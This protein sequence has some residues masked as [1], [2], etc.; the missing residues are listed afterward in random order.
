MRFSAGIGDK[1]TRTGNSHAGGAGA[2]A[3]TDR[4]VSWR[5]HSCVPRR[6]S[7]RR[8]PSSLATVRTTSRAIGCPQGARPADSYVPVQ[9]GVRGRRKT[10]GR[11]CAAHQHPILCCSDR[12]EEGT[13]RQSAAG[14]ACFPGKNDETNPTLTANSFICHKT[15]E[16]NHPDQTQ[17]ESVGVAGDHARQPVVPHARK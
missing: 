3:M 1:F 17:I 14:G 13:E 7:C 10:E 6:H 5:T 16:S 11:S 8:P 2:F 15:S 12:E 9:S 4:P